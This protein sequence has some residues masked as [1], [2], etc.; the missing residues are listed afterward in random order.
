MAIILHVGIAHALEQLRVGFEHMVGFEE[1]FLRG[2]PVA[3]QLLG[4]MDRDVAVRDVP[5]LEV[6]G[7]GAEEFLEARPRP[8]RD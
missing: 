3:G 2:L 6:L 4:D 1:G 8:A 5:V 7:Q